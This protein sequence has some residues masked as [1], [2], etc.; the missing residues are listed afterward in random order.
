MDAPHV[1][2]RRLSSSPLCRGLTE[3]ELD[4]VLAISRDITVEA[5]DH[6]F[7]QGDSADALFFI[8]RGHV[9][10]SRDGQVMATLGI[11]EA[12]GELSVLGGGYKR[13]ASAKALSEVVAVRVGM[14]EFRKLLEAWNIA[15]MKITVNL[16]PQLIERIAVLNDRVLA[17]EKKKGAPASLPHWK[18]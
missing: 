11:G 9:E 7:K 10:I 2:R 8:G 1:R 17:A 6:V 3:A 14:R 12:L 5:G 4:E 15:A 13:S 18:L 16:T